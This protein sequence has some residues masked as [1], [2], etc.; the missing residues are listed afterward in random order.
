MNKRILFLAHENEVDH[1][2]HLSSKF[3]EQ[4]HKIDFFV[5]DFFSYFAG[6]NYVLKKVKDANISIQ[7]IFHINRIN[8]KK[9]NYFKKKLINLKSRYD[10]ILKLLANISSYVGNRYPGKYSLINS[11]NINFNNDYLG[12]KKKFN[13]KFL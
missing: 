13:T 10:L 12:N 7:N 6:K 11:I 8:K 1:V 9:I 2:I 5:C 4:G 3:A